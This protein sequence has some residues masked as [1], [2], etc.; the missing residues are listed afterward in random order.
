[1]RSLQERKTYEMK[2]PALR[3][4]SRTSECRGRWERAGDGDGED[5][6]GGGGGGGSFCRNFTPERSALRNQPRA[7]KAVGIAQDVI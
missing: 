1:M 5:G 7:P 3:P 6:G 4:P 2:S